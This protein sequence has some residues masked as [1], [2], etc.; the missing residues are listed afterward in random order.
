MIH[1]SSLKYQLRR[2]GAPADRRPLRLLGLLGAAVIVL[3]ALTF[4]EPESWRLAA[5]VCLATGLAFLLR[6][7]AAPPRRLEIDALTGVTCVGLSLLAFLTFQIQFVLAAAVMASGVA[8]AL[9]P[10]TT[11]RPYARSP[12]TQAVFV[13]L[14]GLGVVALGMGAFIGLTQPLPVAGIAATAVGI[15]LILGSTR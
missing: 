4:A 11:R 6:A 2:Q 8:L 5:I 3:G 15:D 1:A 12:V 13:A 7:R 10:A 14:L 9:R